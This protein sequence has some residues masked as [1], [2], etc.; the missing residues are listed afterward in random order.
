MNED[1]CYASASELAEKIRTKALS[2]VA[3]VTAHLERIEAI[4]PT[5]NAIVIFAEDTL[6]KAQEAEAAVMRGDA[7][8]PLHGVPYTL[9][10]CIETAG[11]RC[12]QGSKLLQEFVS[13]Q[14]ALVY[15]RL[16]EAGGILLGKTNMP[17]FALWWETDNMVFG[18]TNNP[19][20]LERTP[21]GS[22]GGEAAAIAAGLS[23]LGLGTDLGGSIR[24]PAAFCGIVG[25]KPTLGRVPYTGIQPQTLLRAIHVGPMART[26]PD[27][28]LALSV[29]A[30][31]DD[32]DVYCPPVPVPDYTALDV[33]HP[34]LK[35]GWSA[36]AGIPV[37]PE[38]SHNVAA[39]AEALASS[40][41]EV[42]AVEIAGLREKDAGDISTIMYRAEAGRHLAPV[43]AGRESELTELLRLRYVE[44]PNRSFDDYLEAAGKWEALKQEVKAYFTRYDLF[45]CPTV[46]MCAFPHRQAEFTI[47][48][49]TLGGRHAL[50]GTLP[51]DLTGSP[52]ISVPF[53]WSAEGLPL[54]VQLVG[55]HYDE[56]TLLRAANVLEACQQEH[57]RPPLA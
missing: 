22:S 20:D 38:V 19:W 15:S 1:I 4:N 13:H 31:P 5:L 32:R 21:G 33:P 56:L 54:A 34:T 7:L 46:P 48:G 36:T 10:D 27:I 37:E 11:L 12:T 49:Q 24:E 52:A 40:G 9:K 41:L 29:L 8:G 16:R 23:S 3:V 2:P 45:L 53:G 50:R 51:W 35:V 25:L 42:E 47:A 17:E 28:A 6:E 14:D 30:G 57:R 26:V 18:R 44:T 55:R 39:A 43:V